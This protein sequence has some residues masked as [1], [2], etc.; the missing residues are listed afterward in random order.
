MNAKKII[1]CALA[2]IMG[3]ATFQN[4][5]QNISIG[6]IGDITD[7]I[8]CRCMDGGCYGG[9]LISLRK[10]CGVSNDPYYDCSQN[11]NNCPEK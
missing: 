7:K 8:H 4:K 2:L 1:T 6:D 5:A 3:V 11:A 9:N 10:N